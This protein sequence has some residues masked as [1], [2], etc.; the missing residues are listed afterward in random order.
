MDR[1]PRLRGRP[2]TSTSPSRLPP[3][4]RRLLMAGE[5]TREEMLQHGGST[6][7][8][9]L[10]LLLLLL[11]SACSCCNTVHSTTMAVLLTQPARSAG[12]S[13]PSLQGSESGAPPANTRVMLCRGRHQLPQRSQSCIHTGSQPPTGGAHDGQQV[14]RLHM[15]AHVL[16]VVHRAAEAHAVITPMA[17][18][19]PLAFHPPGPSLS[20]CTCLCALPP[21]DEDM[22]SAGP[23]AA[24]HL[25]ACTCRMVFCLRFLRRPTVTL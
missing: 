16:N 3:V 8:I 10:L 5:E 13:C 23:A 18:R 17:C 21:A 4:G 12:W 11:H 25:P 6:A 1:K 9:A 14:A 2:L 19:L 20:R 15:A 24:P 7:V 22:S